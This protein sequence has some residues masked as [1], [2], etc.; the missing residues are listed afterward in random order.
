MSLKVQ[1][2]GMVPKRQRSKTA[3]IKHDTPHMPVKQVTGSAIFK[4]YHMD[5]FSRFILGALDKMTPRLNTHPKLQ[6]KMISI[7]E[8]VIK[9]F[10]HF[11]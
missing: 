1:S 2:F 11:E 5:V 4:D 7:T 6:A 9:R 3:L 8:N 10:A